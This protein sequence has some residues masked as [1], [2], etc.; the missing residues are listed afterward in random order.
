M[1]LSRKTIGITTFFAIILAWIVLSLMFAQLRTNR[2]IDRQ[3]S[4]DLPKVHSRHSFHTA[5]TELTDDIIAY[6]YAATINDVWTQGDLR[7]LAT[8]VGLVLADEN[9]VR[10]FHRGGGLPATDILKF[11]FNNN[12]L[13]ALSHDCLLGVGT[14]DTSGSGRIE[15][16]RWALY[17]K[18]NLIDMLAVDDKL[19]VLDDTGQVL[20]LIDNQFHL[21]AEISPSPTAKLG[22]LAGRLVVATEGKVLLLSGKGKQVESK[23]LWPQEMPPEQIRCLAFDDD[24]LWAGTDTGLLRFTA[25]D[26]ERVLDGFAVSAILLRRKQIYLGGLDGTVRTLEGKTLAEVGVA[27]NHLNIAMGKVL[28]AGAGGAWLVTRGGKTRPLVPPEQLA[29]LPDPYVSAL[30]ALGD[31]GLLVGGLNRGLSLLEP[32]KPAARP[33]ALQAYGVNRIVEINDGYLVATTNGLARLDR[34][35]VVR[36]RWTPKDGL[37]NRY[38]GSVL[39]RNEVIYAATASGLARIAPTGIKAINAFHGLAGNHLYCLADDGKKLYAGGLAGLS[40]LGGPDGLTVERNVTAAEGNLPHNWVHAVLVAENRLVV[41]TYGG[42]V[43]VVTDNGEAT[44]TFETAGVSINPEA[45]VRFGSFFVFGTLTRGLAISRDLQ[46]WNYVTT[47]LP[48]PNV[49]ALAAAPD[50]LWVGTDRGLARLPLSVIAR[51]AQ[52]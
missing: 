25:N 20:Q 30:S 10:I 52:P 6:P 11:S 8:D 43:A 17:R 45:A 35:F 19:F 36:R 7:L 18:K 46:H 15:L 14:V 3:K 33:V 13:Y 41:G 50:A 38:V 22:W 9:N 1:R 44:P 26:T 34:N 12:K 32:G 16:E 21:N 2:E 39:M 51:D 4:T 5:Q 47:G 42:G 40:I 28:V 31:G 48:S 24:S 23:N 49:T 27:V 29:P 37:P